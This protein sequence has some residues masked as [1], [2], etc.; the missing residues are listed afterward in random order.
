MELEEERVCLACTSRDNP[1]LREAMAEA[2]A[3][4]W[5]NAAY[6]L[7]LLAHV[8]LAFLYSPNPPV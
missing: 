8:Q 4:A 2:E 3:E 5:K 7:A 1:S 6:W